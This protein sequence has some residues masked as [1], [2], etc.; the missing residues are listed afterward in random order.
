MILT[1]DDFIEDNDDDAMEYG[2][3]LNLED[4]EA[5]DEVIEALAMKQRLQVY[6]EY[7]FELSQ[8]NQLDSQSTGI[9]IVL[10]NCIKNGDLKICPPALKQQLEVKQNG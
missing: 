3:T 9:L 5:R 2:W 6:V 8:K 1:E 7:L 4:D 10:G